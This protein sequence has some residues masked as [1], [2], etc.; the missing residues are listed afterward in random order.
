MKRGSTL[1]LLE[2]GGGGEEGGRERLEEEELRL[3]S[4]ILLLS[5]CVLLFGRFDSGEVWL[6]AFDRENRQRGRL[7][8]LR[9]SV[10]VKR[11]FFISSIFS[12]Y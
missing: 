11:L 8:D 2:E 9:E 7:N 4:T 10:F 3:V 12:G 1:H 6:F 5:F